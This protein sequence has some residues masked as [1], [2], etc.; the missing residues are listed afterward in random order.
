MGV[1][2]LP[3]A[4]V[5]RIQFDDPHPF[6][7]VRV[8][9]STAVGGLLYPDRQ[10]KLLEQLWEAFY[11]RTGLD[12]SRLAVIDALERSMPAFVRLLSSHR[13]PALRGLTLVRAFDIPARR[14]ERLRVLF[15]QS[16]G[17]PTALLSLPP[18]LALAVLGQAKQDRRLSPERESRIVADLL[19]R[20]GLQ[21]ALA[22]ARAAPAAR[23]AAA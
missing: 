14:P 20:I 2:S 15:R 1:V 6:P 18:T 19:T 7:W 23:V 8:K 4:F 3:R 16:H 5:F 12:D 13:P 17:Q 11:P 21:R 22:G 9:L 10:W